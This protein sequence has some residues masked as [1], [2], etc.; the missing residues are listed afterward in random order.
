MVK[1]AV[2]STLG[3]LPDGQGLLIAVADA[4]YSTACVI[5]S[6]PVANGQFADAAGVSAAGISLVAT[7]V[8]SCCTYAVSV[9]DAQAWVYTTCVQKGAT[10]LF[11]D[12]NRL[13]EGHW[14]S[15]YAC[16]FH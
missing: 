16:M 15:F 3:S 9:D 5:G 4:G 2:S 13:Q 10:R 12:H 1:P 6:V 7:L 14:P 8:A 11:C